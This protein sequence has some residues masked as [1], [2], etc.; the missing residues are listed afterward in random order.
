M[1]QPKWG[2]FNETPKK[3]TIIKKSKKSVPAAGGDEG[4]LRFGARGETRDIRVAVRKLDAVMDLIGEL[5]VSDAML[6]RESGEELLDIV[7]LRKTASQ[8]HKIVREL[9]EAGLS[10]RMA[11][12]EPLFRKMVRLTRDLAAQSNKK[13]ELFMKGEN[14]EIDKTIVELL[15]DPLVHIFRNAA[16]H[17]LETP[18][19]R[20]KAG[21]NPEGRIFLEARNN[22]NE[23][24]ITIRDDGRGLDREK[25]LKQ[26][27]ARGIVNEGEKME[28]E[29]VWD[30]IFAPGFSTAEHITDIS[31]RG[32]GMDVV[33]RNI[34]QLRGA[35]EV[36]S[37]PGQGTTCLLRIPLTLAIIDGMVVESS[38]RKFVIPT[39]NIDSFIDLQSIALIPV[40]GDRYVVSIRDR[41]APLIQVKDFL[42]YELFRGK[43]KEEERIAVILDKGRSLAGI[44]VDRI[45]GSQQV[46]V[47]ALPEYINESRGLSGSAILGD[48]SVALIL[49]TGAV[50]E[51]F[52]SRE[53]IM[54]N[55]DIS[56]A[57]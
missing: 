28:D 50:L 6:A 16:D 30:L 42:S 45:L 21:K 54:E 35:A 43:K 29:D 52:G 33:R 37:I 41:L 12:V 23:I 19:E 5:V 38:D 39:E 47:K 13:I 17:G 2:L 15:T 3:R 22:G 4:E 55:G 7:R 36:S 40:Q 57:E 44:R 27:V 48:G 46:V 34:Q 10:L 53:R 14:T 31:G 51:H 20:E 24:W 18:R 8:M 49:D 9:Q 11:P 26:A 32:V 56:R 25:I 1:P